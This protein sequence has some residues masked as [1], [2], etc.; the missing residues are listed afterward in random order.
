L[1]KKQ[2]VTKLDAAKRQLCTA[3]R[4]FFADYDVL[5]VYTLAHAALEIFERRPKKEG[6]PKIR[7][8]DV[9]KTTCPHLNEKDAWDYLHSVKNFFKHGGSLKSSVVFHEEAVDSVLYF[10]C[11]NCVNETA[12]DQPVQVDAFIIWF[13]ATKAE[14]HDWDR[15]DQ[16]DNFCPGIRTASRQEQKRFGVQLIADAVAGRL[17]FR[18]GKSD[19]P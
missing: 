11:C 10:A 13:L 19:W 4:M 3:I 9:L 16:I 1:T 8:F 15:K 6:G 18:M 5:S 12:P 17:P 7:H 2:T 14:I